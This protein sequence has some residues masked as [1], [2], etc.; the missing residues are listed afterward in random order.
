M[1]KKR[2]VKRFLSLLL[3]CLMILNAPLSALAAEELQIVDM[4]VLADDGLIG[5]ENP[6]LVSDNTAGGTLEDTF[7]SEG[8]ATLEEVGDDL[9]EDD[10]LVM[11]DSPQTTEE[12]QIPVEEEVVESEEAQT[13]TLTEA[14]SEAESEE[15]LL[16][17]EEEVELDSLLLAAGEG[18]E[19]KIPADPVTVTV[20][21]SNAGS[22]VMIKKDITVT[23][24]DKDGSLDVDDAL[25]AAHEAAYAGGAAAG[26]ACGTT[27]YDLSLT[28]LWGNT[29]GAFGYWVNDSSC[30]SLAD[31]IKANDNLVAFIYQDP[32]TWSDAYARFGAAGYT[33]TEGEA[34]TVSVEK[35]GWDAT[36]NKYAFSAFEGTVLTAYD[37][38]RNALSREAYTADGYQVTFQNAGTYYLAASGNESNI[39]VPAVAKVTVEEKAASMVTGIKL[40]RTASTLVVEGTT[41]LTATVEPEEACDVT[42][43][44]TSSDPAVATVEGG[45]V[46]A[47]AVGNAVITASAGTVSAACDVTV[48][49]RPLFSNIQLYKD[50]ATYNKGEAPLVM[51]PE[52]N[53]DICDGYS[54]TA[55]DYLNYLY[56]VATIAEESKEEYGTEWIN[57]SNNWGGWS[58]G[59]PS[60]DGVAAKEAYYSKGYVSIYFGNDSWHEYVINVNKYSTLKS[61]AIDGVTDVKFDRDR[62]NYHAYVDSTAE[63]VKITP[64]AFKST[65]TI[66]INGK[67]V[68][69]AEDYILSYD[70]DK[71]GKMNADITVSMEGQIPTTYM[72]ELEKKPLNDAP[73]IMTQPLEADYIVKE[74]T[75]AMSVVASANGELAYQW[76]SNTTDSNDGGTPI[77]GATEA[78][79]TPSSDT[80]GTIYYY[81]IITNTGKTENNTTVSN[82]ARVTVD[83]DPT[84][85]AKI[86]TLKKKYLT[87]SMHICGIQD[88]FMKLERKHRLFM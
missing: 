16:L 80:T 82:T 22:L 25:Y 57:F 26:Y 69:N 30:S 39:L 73:F 8:A 42:V 71:T 44:W 36:E 18:E 19:A 1:S 52:F 60:S 84:P 45:V 29:S 66:T 56:A 55:P 63:G 27:E 51:D 81:C 21:I 6:V 62:T 49:K 70:W 72:I 2:S 7:T 53:V 37:S 23:D 78:T 31:P 28:K 77:E 85:V 12:P 32:S 47:V 24:Y 15:E 14:E 41:K 3:A 20:T 4:E 76:Y 87:M 33:A 48:K 83:P 50:S 58:G 64:T 59:K 67:Q 34:L 13:E 9:F 61:L 68:N 79:Y 40:N 11:D 17:M 5:S 86:T 54:V 46:T 65:Y 38:E 88:T 10:G 43:N 75:K 74:N 35:A